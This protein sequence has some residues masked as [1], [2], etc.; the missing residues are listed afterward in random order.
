MK[1]AATRAIADI[2]TDEQRAL[3]V[4]IPTMFHPRLHQAVAHAVR[5]AWLTE[6]P[7]TRRHDGVRSLDADFDFGLPDLSAAIST[8]NGR[9]R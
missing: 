4:V 5:E 7:E 9:L 3:G 6:H 2:V 8:G 1:Q